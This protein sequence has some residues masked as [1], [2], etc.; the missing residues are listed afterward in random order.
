MM[1]VVTDEGDYGDVRASKS[2][3]VTEG[4]IIGP[5]LKA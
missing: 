4:H 2:G 1:I 3:L 5:S